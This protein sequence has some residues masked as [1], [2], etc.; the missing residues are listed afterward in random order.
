MRNLRAASEP[1][2]LANGV[3]AFTRLVEE[4]GGIIDEHVLDGHD[5]LSPILALSSGSGEE[6]GHDIVEWIDLRSGER[7]A[8]QS[9]SH[10]V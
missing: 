5:H 10:N 8:S 1:R 2:V 4:K 7:E 9:L 6:W 3:Q